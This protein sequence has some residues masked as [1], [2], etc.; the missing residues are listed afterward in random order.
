MI[1]KIEN[2]P[3][4]NPY[5]F[6][7][8]KKIKIY[9]DGKNIT[10]NVKKNKVYDYIVVKEKIFKE[11]VTDLL[12]ELKIY[13]EEFKKNYPYAKIFKYKF[14][15]D[16]IKNRKFFNKLIVEAYCNSYLE[17][18]NELMV[19]VI[20][21]NFNSNNKKNENTVCFTEKYAFQKIN[22]VDFVNNLEKNIKEQFSKF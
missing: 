10:K 3:V 17:K 7:G 12:K 8:F 15:H 4:Y 16:N 18:S 2:L 13:F 9:V 19:R 1:F 20:F 14:R 6:F 5:R 21:A 11:S 22:F